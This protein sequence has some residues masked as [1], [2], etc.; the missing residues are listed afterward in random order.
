[1]PVHTETGRMARQR[2][3]DYG[4]RSRGDAQI[5]HYKQVIGPEL[6]SRNMETQTIEARIA[7]NALNRMTR[8]GRAAY[9]RVA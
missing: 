7:V 6:R 5:G 3:I 8:L 4:Q 9:E 2:A 1:M